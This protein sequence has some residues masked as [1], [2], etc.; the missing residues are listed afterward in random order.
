MTT[1]FEKVLMRDAATEAEGLG[2]E[3]NPSSTCT[4]GINPNGVHLLVRDDFV[5]L[6]TYDRD[7]SFEDQQAYDL[8]PQITCLERPTAE[9]LAQLLMN[10]LDPD[11]KFDGQALHFWTDAFQFM[12]PDYFNALKRLV[13]KL[14]WTI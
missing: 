14:E 5:A 6:E 13:A 9:V 2:T 10:E 3:L 1:T 12:G 11:G 4:K 8:P 7:V